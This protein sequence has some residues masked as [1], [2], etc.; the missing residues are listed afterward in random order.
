M[1]RND[2]VEK[3]NFEYLYAKFITYH[4]PLRQMAWNLS[5]KKLVLICRIIS[6][7]VSRCVNISKRLLFR[8]KKGLYHGVSN[9]AEAIDIIESN[10]E[11]KLK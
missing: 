11:I 9:I 3:V 6:M 7:T 4:Y 10:Y 1:G 8:K 5:D 2:L